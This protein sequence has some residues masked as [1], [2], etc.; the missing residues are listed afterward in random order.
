MDPTSSDQGIQRF[1]GRSSSGKRYVGFVAAQTSVTSKASIPSKFETILNRDNHENVG[2]GR[3]TF[4]FDIPEND[5]PGP[6]TYA[7][8]KG[9]ISTKKSSLS[10]SNT[11]TSSFASS[12]RA[13]FKED[14]PVFVSPGPGSY[15]TF[16]K[17][18][19]GEV[20]HMGPT[21]V[22]STPT[23]R[24]PIPKSAPVM[25][26]PG[27]YDVIRAES[28]VRSVP[29]SAMSS[30]CPKDPAI[31]KPPAV[32][33]YLDVEGAT[34]FKAVNKTA[35][36]PLAGMRSTTDRFKYNGPLAGA[37]GS[38]E[39]CSPKKVLPPLM[40]DIAQVSALTKAPALVQEALPEQTSP[41]RRGSAPQPTQKPSPMFANTILDRFG[42]PTIR[43]AAPPP[44]NVGPGSYEVERPA[45]KMLISSSWAVSAVPRDAPKDRYQPPGP[46]FYE[47]KSPQKQISH[48]VNSGGWSA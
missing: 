33:A 20:L 40:A 35:T 6:G 30:K 28:A 13:G 34:S 1:A 18:K 25:P 9:G 8:V 27:A 47:V 14:A 3:R 10:F 5:L 2:F 41:K 37:G 48:R 7:T 22:F 16:V 11:G 24:R 46:A 31:G 23:W 26:G 42:R 15:N 45:K 12:K 32:G 36:K 43:Y 19:G 39:G 38:T 17:P 4:R 29:C 44:N 21:S